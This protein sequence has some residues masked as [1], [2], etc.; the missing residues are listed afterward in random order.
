MNPGAQ[1]KKHDFRRGGTIKAQ[2]NAQ[3]AFTYAQFSEHLCEGEKREDDV[4]GGT[5]E[6]RTASA[7]EAF[8]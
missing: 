2:M 6:R 4:N 8:W 7:D 5:R 3:T 1:R